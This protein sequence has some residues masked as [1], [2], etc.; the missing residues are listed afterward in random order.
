[1]TDHLVHLILYLVVVAL[2]DQ[3]IARL[4]L[5][6]EASQVIR[7]VFWLTAAVLIVQH[8]HII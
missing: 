7:G 6:T 3:G 5:K 2:A 1:M 8:F 4:P